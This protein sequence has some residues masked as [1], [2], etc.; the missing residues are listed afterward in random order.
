MD[1]Y[2]LISK[3]AD[4]ATGWMLCRKLVRPSAAGARASDLGHVVWRLLRGGHECLVPNGHNAALGTDPKAILG[5][6]MKTQ[7][8]FAAIR[9][10]RP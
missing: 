4:V 6:G 9:T 2:F 7:K 1:T 8:D 5:P 3:L 10:R